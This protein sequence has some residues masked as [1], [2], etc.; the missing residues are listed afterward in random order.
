MLLM[1]AVNK[2]FSVPNLSRANE[3]AP[4]EVETPI[5]DCTNLTSFGIKIWIFDAETILK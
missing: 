4:M 3:T 5:F 2:R 1:L